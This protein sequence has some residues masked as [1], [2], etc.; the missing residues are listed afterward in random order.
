ML[1]IKKSQPRI[2]VTGFFCDSDLD[3]DYFFILFLAKL[4]PTKPKP[5]SVSVAGSG[6]GVV[7]GL[8]LTV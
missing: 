7:A 5:N 3:G 1:K 4:S 6:I 2:A 8:R